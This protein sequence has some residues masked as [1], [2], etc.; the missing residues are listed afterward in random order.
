[1]RPLRAGDEQA[2]RRLFRAT[3]A[4]GKQLPF[5]YPALPAYEALCLDWYLGAGREAA[6]VLCVGEDVVGYTLVCLD[7]RAYRRWAAPA[8]LAWAA[9][10][11]ARI[12]ARRMPAEA[13]RFERLRLADGFARPGFEPPAQA[14]AHVNLARGVRFGLGGLRLA[15]HVDDRCREAGLAAWYGEVNA[16]RGRRAIALEARS[17]R[18][19]A[20]APNRTLTWLAG[21]PVERLTIL[22][23]IGTASARA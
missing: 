13:V 8:G 4:M 14:H 21:A 16:L 5:A 18:I 10:A 11:A 17:G 12:L 22:R 1:M 3:V 2:V 9:A 20:R 6:G 19:V 7:E 15:Q 23:T